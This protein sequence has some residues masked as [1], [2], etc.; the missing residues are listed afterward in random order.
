MRQ[1][2]AYAIDRERVN[3]ISALGTSFAA[4]GILPSFYKAFYEEPEQT[5]QPADVELANQM[6]DDAGWRR[7]GDGRAD[8]GRPGALV[9]PLRALGV[10]V[11]HPGGAA[12]RG[13]GGRDRGRVQRPGGQHGQADRAHDAQGRRRCRRRTSTPSSG[14]GAATR[15]TRASCSACSSRGEIGASSDSFYSNPEYDRLFEEQSG[16][17]DVEERKELIQEMVALTQG[18]AALPRPHRGPEPGRPTAPTG[19]RS[20]SSFCPSE[21]G[22]L[23][24]EQ[25]SYEPLLSLTPARAPPTTAAA[26]ARR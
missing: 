8:Q 9:R 4:N 2:I 23:L 12:D 24:C 21:T 14:A 18:D 17:F 16:E 5:Y 20:R 25:T 13:A 3:E 1:A 22:D 11:R 19:S 15:T 6:L 10:A 26:A 7:D